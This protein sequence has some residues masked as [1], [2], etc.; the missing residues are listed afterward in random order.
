MAHHNH[1]HPHDRQT[2]TERAALSGDVASQALNEALRV[3]FRLLTLAMLLVALLFL[4]SGIFTVKQHERAFILRFGK[5]VLHRDAATGIETPVLGP[6][7]HFA[8]PFLVDE[9]VRFPVQRELDL[10]VG[11]FW[12]LE[13]P[14]PGKPVPESIAPG[15]GGY[16]LTGD[17]NILHSRWIVTYT[18]SDPVKFCANLADPAELAS[19]S[20]GS[21]VRSLLTHLTESAVIHTMAR[22]QVDDAY[23]GRR[24]QLQADVRKALMAQLKPPHP[25]YGIEINNVILEV[26]TPPVQT[27]R[28]FDDVTMAGEE[29]RKAVEAAKGYFDK[30][31]TEA[32]GNADRRRS[33][34]LAYKTQVVA[35]AEADASYMS[36]LL[37]QYPNDRG[38]L[39][40]F[41]SQRLIEV[42]REVLERAE[43]VYVVH[44]N[45]EVRLWLSREPEAVRQIIKWRSEEAKDQ[46]EKPH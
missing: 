22:Y 28:A 41:L 1:D 18:V 30:T 20:P 4:G 6:G 10:A 19:N 14:Q 46:D 45:G 39:S 27:K 5:P 32:V 9:V 26:V 38:M 35:E 36:D 21:R 34:A 7:L 3:S 25:D 23:R 31:I 24:S 15:Q 17:V 37:K 43:E 13:A 29:S 44:T 16:N 33:E 42:T 12:Y 2:A 11:S 8:W 40:H